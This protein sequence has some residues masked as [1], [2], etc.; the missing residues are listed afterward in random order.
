MWIGGKLLAVGHAQII[1]RTDVKR[2]GHIERGIRPK[3]HPAGIEQIQIGLGHLR[4]ELA[5]D[6]GLLPA[7]HPPDDILHC[8]WAG[9]GGALAGVDIELAKAVEEIG[10]TQLANFGVDGV[11][12]PGEGPLGPKEPSRVIWA[13]LT[14][15]SR[16][17][18]IPPKMRERRRGEADGK[19][20]KRMTI[21]F[22]LA[23][24]QYLCFDFALRLRSERTG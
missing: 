17:K 5:I 6:E 3:Q 4:P 15:G 14:A 8:R 19:R 10:P 2:P 1:C 12:R 7:R 20:W 21:I 18:G 23:S 11:V 22:S 9:E 24:L 13:W 16:K